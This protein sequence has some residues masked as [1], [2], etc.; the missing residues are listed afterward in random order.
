MRSVA[1][2]L[3]LEP[4]ALVL[5]MPVMA[6]IALA[7]RLGDEDASLFATHANIDEDEAGARLLARRAHGRR[8]SRAAQPER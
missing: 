4:Q 1:D 5:D 3:R 8:P 7:L 2:Q 6:R